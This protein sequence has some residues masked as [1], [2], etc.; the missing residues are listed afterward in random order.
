MR[1][2]AVGGSRQSREVERGHVSSSSVD[3]EHFVGSS[4]NH[5]DDTGDS[6]IVGCTTVSDQGFVDLG[7]RR[8]STTT[9]HS[10]R[11]V[12]SETRAVGDLVRTRVYQSEDRAGHTTVD[13]GQACRDSW[14]HK[15]GGTERERLAA[16]QSPPQRLQTDLVVFRKALFGDVT[17][18]EHAVVQ[19]RTDDTSDNTCRQGDETATVETRHD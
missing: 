17:A 9:V 13:L 1:N 14:C 18:R 12:S 7:H 2:T 6:D 8:R 19:N 10:N 4:S 15:P 11:T 3:G 16:G 5:V